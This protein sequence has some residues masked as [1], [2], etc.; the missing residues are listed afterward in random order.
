MNDR[1]K[2]KR[3]ANGRLLPGQGALNPGGRPKGIERR[4]R[5]LIE[6]KKEHEDGL[7]LNG[8]EAIAN[9]MYKIAMGKKVK[10]QGVVGT[11][12]ISIKDRIAAANFLYDRVY[13]KPTV[14]V[15]ADTTVHQGNLENIDVDA[16]PKDELEALERHVE[17][18]A[19]KAMGKAT[20][21]IL[22]VPPSDVVEDPER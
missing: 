15:E 4:I 21:N 13:G 17:N 6:G 11:G 18:L 8:W 2:P 16:L 22:D 9:S 14:K 7:T 1:P 20:S 10:I 5:E 12:E 3:D 19:A